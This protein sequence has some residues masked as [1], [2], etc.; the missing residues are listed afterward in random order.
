MGTSPHDRP[1]RARAAVALAAAGL[2]LG[3]WLWT[4]PG[5]IGPAPAPDTAGAVSTDAPT[6][7][8]PWF[9][10]RT[11]GSG[12]EFV[13][14]NGEEADQYTLLESLGGGVALLDYDGDG[15]L[16]VFLSGGGE[17]TGPT[18]TTITG[19]PCRLFRNLGGFRFE[20]VTAAA[21]PHADWWYTHGAAVADYDRDGWPDLFVT[22]YGRVALFHNEPRPAGGR[23]LVDRTAAAG[24]AEHGWCT[25]AAWADIN[26]DGFPDLYVCRYLD[27]SFANHPVCPGFA[28]G[29]PRDICAPQR[30]NPLAH[31]LFV[32]QKGASFRE[33]GPD[34]GFRPAGGGLGVVAADVNADARPDFYVGNDA[35]NNFLF[36][37]RN[38]RLEEAAWRAGVAVDDDGRYDASMGV[39]AGDYDGTGR[40]SLWV[41]NYQD[42]L[43]ALYRNLG[44]P[45]PNESFDHQ[46]RAAGVAVVGTHLVGFGTGF[47]DIDGDG[48]EDLV[49]VNGHVL[50]RPSLVST[51]RQKPVLLRNVDRNGRRA[52]EDASA[53]GGEYFRVPAL[54]RGLAIGDL[55]NDGRPDL[56]V[57]HTNSPAAVL[58]NVAPPRPWLGVR[59]VGRGGRDVVGSTVTV[60]GGARPLTRFAKGGGSYLSASDP[61]L[62][63]ATGEESVR[64]VTV[65]WS[66]GETQTWEGLAPGA[67]WELHEG[68]RDARRLSRAN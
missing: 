65:R 31:R 32:N 16:D 44:H 27:W 49:F 47:V 30:F 11:R 58:R 1:G 4:R 14:G 21:G 48:W 20:D 23:R 40:A 2:G 3:L 67:Y 33:G 24:L 68:E 42:E 52:F 45:A 63:F 39:D 6:P 28:P 37:N 46:S 13:Y 51:F 54:G 18:R 36:L 12:L 61:R 9:E 43:H 59:L 64:T 8:P 41:T 57:S 50:R 26:G 55:D 38:G 7:G 66:W 29:V 35:A 10:D 15:R 17:F 60:T 56:V 53:R 25:S 19:R 34:H 62:L 5:T 22:G